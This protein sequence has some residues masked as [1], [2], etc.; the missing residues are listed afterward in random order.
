MFP[1]ECE[2]YGVVVRVQRNDAQPLLPDEGNMCTR[3]G[4]STVAAPLHPPLALRERKGKKRGDGHL[5][6]CILR[7]FSSLQNETLFSLEKKIT[8]NPSLSPEPTHSSQT[9]QGESA[10]TTH[11]DTFGAKTRKEADKTRNSTDTPEKDGKARP[12]LEPATFRFLTPNRSGYWRKEDAHPWR[13]IQIDDLVYVERFMETYTLNKPVCMGFAVLEYSKLI[14]YNYYYNIF[15]KHW[16]E[17]VRLL[18]TDT[19]SFMLEFTTEDF[20]EDVKKF[21]LTH[22]LYPSVKQLYETSNFGRVST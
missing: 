11:S 9:L 18:Y 5:V 8:Q 14:M 19:D 16:G 3:E 2:E 10:H 17:S 1:E 20:Y 12:G 7:Y 21:E 4:L 15:K 22:L 6:L 13:V